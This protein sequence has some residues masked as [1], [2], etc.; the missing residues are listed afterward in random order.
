MEEKSDT[1]EWILQYLEGGLSGEELDS[2]Y[3]FVNAGK[4]NKQLY[5]ELKA[6]YDALSPAKDPVYIRQSWQR[7]LEKKKGRSGSLRTLW[8]PVARYA[9]V[10]L[11]A[12][13]LTSLFFYSASTGEPGQ[14]TRYIGGDGLEADI[15]VLPDG[16]KVSLGSKTTF[17]Y[18]GDYGK[19]SRT[20]FLEGEAYFEVAPDAARAFIVKTAVQD[21][22]AL[23]TKFNVMAYRQ[24][25]LT[26]TTLL[27]GAVSLTMR[28]ESNGKGSGK[29]ILLK[30]DEQLIY[31]HLS[32][33]A[34]L[35]KVDASQFTSWTSGYYYFPDQSL[36]SI[37]C[38]LSYVYGVEFTVESE[39]L[40][41]R[42]FNGTFYRGQSIKDIMEIIHLSIPIDYTIED[43]H[44]TLREL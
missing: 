33:Q 22:R 11:L 20:V 21:I 43:H 41:R 6:L 2:F 9:A 30:P 3:A 38:R 10:A 23:G 34:R 32:G 27:E 44:V 42:M 13:G 40:N 19:T 31:N 37:L 26:V 5:F 28:G 36:R 16:T 1:S 12:V 18:E 25:S 39:G 29:E 4:E 17:R 35:S 15:V 7:L 8:K 24:D 14:T